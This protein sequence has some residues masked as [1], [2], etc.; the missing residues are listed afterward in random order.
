MVQTRCIQHGT[1][2]GDGADSGGL[3]GVVSS[4]SASAAGASSNYAAVRRPS[5]VGYPVEGQEDLD[6]V[7]DFSPGRHFRTALPAAATL[8]S[9][10]YS[11]AQRSS[12]SGGLTTDED[13]E[14]GEVAEEGREQG[15]LARRRAEGGGDWSP[16]PTL[17]E[18]QRLF[19]DDNSP[20]YFP[21]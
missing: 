21:F 5:D 1:S 11:Y 8:R 14:L 10:L 3:Q 15:Q 9:G 13:W 20:P 6:C 19:D 4:S 2:S 17:H 12:A 7:A 18:Q 16:L